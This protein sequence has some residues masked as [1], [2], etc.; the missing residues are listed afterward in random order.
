MFGRHLGWLVFDWRYV[1]FAFEAAE[2]G[3][4]RMRVIGDEC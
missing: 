1:V 4:K 3:V 2:H